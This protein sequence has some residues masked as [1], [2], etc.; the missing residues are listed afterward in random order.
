MKKF[1]RKRKRW[2]LISYDIYSRLTNPKIPQI[3]WDEMT[4][5]ILSLPQVHEC[6]RLLVAERAKLE[7]VAYPRSSNRI[8]WRSCLRRR[9]QGRAGEIGSGG[10]CRT[11]SL[12]V[13]G[14]EEFFFFFYTFVLD[15]AEEFPSRTENWLVSCVVGYGPWAGRSRPTISL[16]IADGPSPNRDRAIVDRLTSLLLQTSFFFF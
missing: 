11:V 10:V 7:L 14:K 1:S 16:S 5:K 4:P 9:T 12:W 13:N 2:A 3:V 8:C 15:R 6:E